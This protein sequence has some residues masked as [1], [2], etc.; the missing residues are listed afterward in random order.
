MPDRHD[1]AKCAKEIGSATVCIY[2]ISVFLV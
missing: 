2:L 1:L